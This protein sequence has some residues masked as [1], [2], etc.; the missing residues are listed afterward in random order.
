MSRR[1]FD[2][3]RRTF[4]GVWI[5]DLHLGSR[6][7]RAADLGD[8]LAGLA[9]ETLYLVGD[10]IDLW[11]LDRR[12]WWPQAHNEVLRRLLALAR[13][14]TRVVYVP[15]NHDARF[16]VHAGQHFGQIEVA[17]EAVHRR[18]NGERLLVVHGDAFDG[19]VTASRWTGALGAHAYEWLLHANGVV[20][21]V[22]HRCGFPYWSLAGFIKSRVPNARDYIRRYEQAAAMAA[23]AGGF[24]GVVCGHIHHPA[25]RRIGAVAYFNCGDWVESCTALVEHQDGRMELVSAQGVAVRSH[26][27]AVA[28]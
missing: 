27:A 23:A 16:R 6:A 11:A 1:S 9:C 7:A 3:A 8:F 18:A 10:V 25:Q 21:A 15:G 24:D 4:R 5:S 26:A 20:N 14:G 13:A 22:R 28:A 2:T 17:R 19:A 12:P